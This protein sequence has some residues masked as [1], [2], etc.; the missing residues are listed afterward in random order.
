MQSLQAATAL[1]T[2]R[3]LAGT[4]RPRKLI[5]QN[6]QPHYKTVRFS[7]YRRNATVRKDKTETG[8]VRSAAIASDIATGSFRYFSERPE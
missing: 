1:Q 8:N 6:Q 3:Q 2:S 7:K 4:I 5:R